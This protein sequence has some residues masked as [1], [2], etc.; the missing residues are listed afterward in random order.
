MCTFSRVVFASCSHHFLL[1][2]I[3]KCDTRQAY[4]AGESASDCTDTRIHGLKSLKVAAECKDCKAKH[5]ST[6]D[7]LAKVRALIR[8]VRKEFDIVE[9]VARGD[10]KE[11]S[12]DAK[13]DG[14]EN[15]VAENPEEVCK[16]FEGFDGDISPQEF[17]CQQGLAPSAKKGK[18]E[19][20]RGK[21]SGLE[22]YVYSLHH[23]DDIL[24]SF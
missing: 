17:L 12:A 13:T 21:V 10:A 4:E 14:A 22:H 6:S 24:E 23:L 20:R 1:D 19:S 11:V 9:T 5:A 15:L 7:K 18:K 3:T 8:G 2:R 16:G